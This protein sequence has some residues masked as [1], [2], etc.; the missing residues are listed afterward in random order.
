MGIARAVLAALPGLESH[1][2]V[3]P[4]FAGPSDPGRQERVLRAVATVFGEGPGEPEIRRRVSDD[5]CRCARRIVA[6]E[7]EEAMP[8]VV[9]DGSQGRL[10]RLEQA[11][12]ERVEAVRPGTVSIASA[13]VISPPTATRTAT[14]SRARLLDAARLLLRTRRR[15]PPHRRRRRHRARADLTLLEPQRPSA[16]PHF[17][18][19]PVGSCRSV[20]TDACA[21]QVEK[22]RAPEHTPWRPGPGRP[23]SLASK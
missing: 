14:G 11:L 22:R 20:T 9:G 3:A 16:S 1:H 6:V 4:E 2:E 23:W 21:A 17:N 15:I 18:G 12:D 10:D 8:A 7:R 19:P 13:S 5:H